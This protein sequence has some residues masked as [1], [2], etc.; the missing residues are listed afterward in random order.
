MRPTG[1]GSFVQAEKAILD[2]ILCHNSQLRPHQHNGGLAS[3]E[4]SIFTGSA[5]TMWSKLVDHYNQ[6]MEKI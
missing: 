1:Y 6:N 4:A 2:Y 3:N 5:I